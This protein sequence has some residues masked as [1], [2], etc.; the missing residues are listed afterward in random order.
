MGNTTHN[1][2]SELA[3]NGELHVVFG[4]GPLGLAVMRELVQGGRRV[5]MVNR[6]G[7]APV[8]AGV[9]VVQGDTFNPESVREA[10]AGA[11]VVYQCAQ[12]AYN[13][14]VTRFPRM[15]SA[16]I[17][18]L[19]AGESKLVAPENLYMYGRVFGPIT[20]DLPYNAH[21]RKGEVRARMAEQ[22]VEAHRTGKLRTTA[23]RASDF[24]GPDALLGT[25]GE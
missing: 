25:P 11:L 19:A 17:D 9:Q 6:S 20:E 5:R 14:W 15:Q 23:G 21:T 3:L 24:Y 1:P 13:E 18:G 16:I 7:K 4:T 12:P 8:P 10:A 2:A 22:V